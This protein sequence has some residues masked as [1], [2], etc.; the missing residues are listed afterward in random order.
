M[1]KSCVTLVTYTA[2][3]RAGDLWQS[4]NGDLLFK[5]GSPVLLIVGTI[6]NL[7]AVITLQSPLFKSSSISFLLATLALCDVLVLNT[8]LM[9]WWLFYTFDIDVRTLSNYGCKVHYLFT[10]YSHQIASWTL[11]LLT[12]ERTISVILPLRCRELCNKRRIVP[13]WVAIAVIFFCCNLHFLFSFQLKESIH[14]RSNVTTSSSQCDVV[15]S[16]NSF[17]LVPWSWIDACLGDFIPFLAVFSGNVIIITHIARS[18]RIRSQEMQV[19]AKKDGKISSTIF[20]F[21]TVSI[22]FLI[23]NIPSDLNFLG[24]GY[25]LFQDANPEQKAVENLFFAAVSLLYYFNNA[26]EFLLYFVSG[27]KFRSAFV[28]MFKCW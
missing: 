12:V 9:R 13:V 26:I 5:Y 25:G 6:G 23:C 24:Y 17:L 8:G 20:L 11:V 10:Y 18:R 2:A 7:I 1:G 15:E 14:H 16:W 28:G 27:R 19:V 22:I 4:R 21:I 3:V